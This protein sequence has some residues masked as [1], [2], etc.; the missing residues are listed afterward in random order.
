MG[1]IYQTGTLTH[2]TSFWVEFSCLVCSSETLENGFHKW[3]D[4]GMVQTRGCP[5]FF[6]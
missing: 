2:Q 4:D 5:Y 3:C 6:L 1:F